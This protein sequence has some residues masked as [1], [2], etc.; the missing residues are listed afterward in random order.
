METSGDTDAGGMMDASAATAQVS[1]A[2][3]TDTVIVTDAGAAAE[4]G[5]ATG[6]VDGDAATDPAAGDAGAARAD[7]A[8]ATGAAIGDTNAEV[9]NAEPEAPSRLAALRAIMASHKAEIMS[10][11]RS[12]H[13]DRLG[14]ALGALIDTLVDPL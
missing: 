8:G 7:T 9:T 1:D 4:A 10:A 12:G 11:A 14:A 2:G 6:H 5:A 3:V 13:L